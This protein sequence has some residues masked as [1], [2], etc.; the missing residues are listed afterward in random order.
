MYF[1]V[2]LSVDVIAA[3]NFLTLR[4]KGIYFNIFLY[5]FLHFAL[6]PLASA[7]YPRAMYIYAGC[8]PC[9]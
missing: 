8:S 5:L 2:L 1:R 4:G 7:V 3:P 6:Y 9:F